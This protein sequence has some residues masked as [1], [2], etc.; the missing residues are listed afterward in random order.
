[1]SLISI[2]Q[3]IVDGFKAALPALQTCE[4][5]GGRF[6]A[7]ELNRISRRVPALFVA[8][9]NIGD[10][11]SGHDGLSCD[12]TY[13]AFLITKDQPGQSRDLVS[14]ALLDAALKTVADNRW[15]LDAAETLPANISAS[16]LYGANIDRQAVA[17]WGITWRQRMNAGSDVDDS[18]LADFLTFHADYDVAPGVDD[19]PIATDHVALPQE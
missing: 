3:A 5:H 13:G 15:G 1:M 18:E 14:L 12:V 8:S 2:Q 4:R 9:L 6:D 17:M 19:N 7:G 11:R 10:V 16:N